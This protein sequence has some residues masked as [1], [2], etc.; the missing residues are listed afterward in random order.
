LF[1]LIQFFSVKQLVSDLDQRIIAKVAF[2]DAV[3]VQI[4]R[5]WDEAQP[6]STWTFASPTPEQS[7]P[8][9]DLALLGDGE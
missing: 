8:I 7:H 6:N 5:S 9:M 4:S 1:T 3:R 2:D